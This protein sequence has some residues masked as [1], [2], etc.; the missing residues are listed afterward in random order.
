MLAASKSSGGS[1]LTL[2]IFPLILVAGYMLLVRPQRNRQRQMVDMRNKIEPG[3][4]VVTTAGLIATVVATD[5]ETVTLE[6]APGVH[7]RFLRQAVVR[8]VVDE[9]VE[10]EPP[11]EPAPDATDEAPPETAQ[12]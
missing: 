7:S 12:A 11:V 3:V 9:P 4:E 2:L 6:I 1:S 10:P 5:D 8:V